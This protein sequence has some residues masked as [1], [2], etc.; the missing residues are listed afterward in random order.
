MGA[1]TPEFCEYVYVDGQYYLIDY[2]LHPGSYCYG[3]DGGEER[4]A[5]PDPN[6]KNGELLQQPPGKF[7]AN[8][9]DNLPIHDDHHEA[10]DHEHEHDDDHVEFKPGDLPFATYR[11]TEMEKTKTFLIVYSNAGP[12]NHYHF[13]PTDLLAFLDK[14]DPE[15]AKK[16]RDLGEAALDV[17]LNLRIQVDAS[18]I[19]G[20]LKKNQE[21]E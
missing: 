4:N 15:K 8:L 16:Y 7:K 3:Y 12:Q 14:H 13:F 17:D 10:G 20:S 2:H 5:A 19:E 21:G 1:D 9:H 18:S 11:Y 6:R